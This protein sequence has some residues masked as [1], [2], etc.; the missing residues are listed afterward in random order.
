[1]L[2]VFRLAK[3]FYLLSHSD[4]E[5]EL[6]ISLRNWITV[7]WAVRFIE[8]CLREVMSQTCNKKMGEKEPHQVKSQRT[9]C[10][11]S[12]CQGM[13]TRHQCVKDFKPLVSNMYNRSYDNVVKSTALKKLISSLKFSCNSLATGG[14]VGGLA[15]QTI[16][17]TGHFSMQICRATKEIV[18]LW[19]S[20]LDG[21]RNVLCEV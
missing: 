6:N 11:T 3:Q 8:N 14:M 19:T 17:L 2:K 13:F 4:F 1:M 5:A 20:I 10:K 18:I 15:K 12:N 16:D 21:R 7:S 9:R